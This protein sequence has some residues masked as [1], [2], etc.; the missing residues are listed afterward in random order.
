MIK[1]R[2][3]LPEL[4]R[5]L[6]LPMIAAEIGVASGLFS[7]DLLEQGIEL[8]YS[9]DAWTKLDQKGD[10]GF[11]QSWH[12]ENYRSTIELL[13]KFKEKPIILKG[14]SNEM[15][16]KVADNTLGLLYLDGDHSYEGVMKDL[17]SWYD[18]VVK[19]GIIASHD[20]LNEDYKVKEAFTDFCISKD[21][22]EII[23]IPEN[24]T[25][26]AGGYFFKP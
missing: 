3:Q 8:L 17:H 23:L 6:K 13:R 14:V 12:D 11:P 16:K 26:D 2:L 24:K 10:G 19:G 18:K 9:V 22:R 5:E 21:I 7:R 15:A 25:E 4:M 1:H 20:F